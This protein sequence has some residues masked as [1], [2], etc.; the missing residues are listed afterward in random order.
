[1]VL[2]W[3]ICVWWR[4]CVLPGHLPIGS[5]N[6]S[7]L[8]AHSGHYVNALMGCCLCLPIMHMSVVGRVLFF[9]IFV[10]KVGIFVYTL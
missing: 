8:K 2:C 9:V 3:Y 5:W 10:D 4:R 7:T 6:Q 1:M